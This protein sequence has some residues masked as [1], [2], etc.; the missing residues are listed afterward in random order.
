[1]SM[2]IGSDWLSGHAEHLQDVVDV[3]DVE[4]GSGVIQS[5][6]LS[7]VG[8]RERW[9]AKT[10]RAR[11]ERELPSLEVEWSELIRAAVQQAGGEVDPANPRHSDALDEQ[12]NALETITTRKL[13]VLTGSAGTGKTS[14]VGAL[15]REEKLAR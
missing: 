9:L 15:L 14:V 3:L 6:Q 7:A 8:E 2:S 10:L 5:V 13:S 1:R 4:S 11:A 12:A